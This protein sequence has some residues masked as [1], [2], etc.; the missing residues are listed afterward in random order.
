MCEESKKKSGDCNAT[1]FIVSLHEHKSLRM[2]MKESWKKSNRGIK[3]DAVTND[4][5]VDMA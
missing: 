4:D 2:R 3:S 5:D 1:R